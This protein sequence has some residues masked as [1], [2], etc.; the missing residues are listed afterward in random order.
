MASIPQPPEE[1]ETKTEETQENNDEEPDKTDTEKESDLEQEQGSPIVNE[2]EE[3][4]A[5][6]NWS[7]W[8]L[9]SP[10]RSF[11]LLKDIYSNVVA[12][13]RLWT[14][15][16]KIHGQLVARICMKRYRLLWIMK[17]WNVQ[18]FSFTREHVC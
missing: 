17:V 18:N 3:M 8:L 9:L 10:M 16:H 4:E 15:L 1:K 2:V 12:A 7:I 6:G 11:D 5:D 13:K 14:C